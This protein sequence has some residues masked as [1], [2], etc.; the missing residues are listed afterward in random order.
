[1][2]SSELPCRA[3]QRREQR[4]ASTAAAS[5]RDEWSE[6]R[7]PRADDDDRAQLQRAAPQG[8][9]ITLLSRVTAVWARALP[10]SVAL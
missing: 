7:R 2:A 3:R 10:C 5:I 9:V 6:R 4:A 8:A 1:M